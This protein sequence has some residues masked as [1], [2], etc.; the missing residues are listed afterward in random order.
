MAGLGSVVAIGND[1]R[2]LAIKSGRKA[3]FSLVKWDNKLFQVI[4]FLHL[5]P[6]LRANRLVF[7]RWPASRMY[8]RYTRWAGPL[9]WP[10]DLANGSPSGRTGKPSIPSVS[11]FVNRSN[12]WQLLELL[13]LYHRSTGLA[14]PP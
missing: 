2:G 10:P 1:R 9:A 5:W 3:C 14:D 11:G 8:F 7:G 12:S 6:V 13:H 4:F